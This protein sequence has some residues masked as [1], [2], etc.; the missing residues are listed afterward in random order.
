MESTVRQ[1][2]VLDVVGSKQGNDTTEGAHVTGSTGNKDGNGNGFSSLTSPSVEGTPIIST[3]EDPFKQQ[4]GSNPAWKGLDG[5]DVGTSGTES[6]GAGPPAGQQPANTASRGNRGV[7]G[8][9]GIN[10]G[11]GNGNSNGN[12]NGNSNSNSNS[13]GNAYG[14]GLGDGC[15]PADK[16][17]CNDNNRTTTSGNSEAEGAQGYSA[18]SPGGASSPAAQTGNGT[19]GGGSS[20]GGGGGSGGND[21][22]N[23]GAGPSSGSNA[24]FMLRLAG[25]GS[26][27]G[28][29][30]RFLWAGWLQV[31]VDSRRGS[32][33]SAVPY[34]VATLCDLCSCDC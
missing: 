13:E 11:N 5:N 10:D 21:Q 28:S 14:K 33:P 24:L 17:L 1:L 8:G 19:A 2:K 15:G 12:G 31:T 23:N 7:S 32:D 34:L 4:Q 30:S 29:G 6:Q 20:S 22:S 16:G 25:N 27:T 18:S 26:S 3:G 9:D